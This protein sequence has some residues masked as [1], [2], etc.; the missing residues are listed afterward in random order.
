M[1]RASLFAVKVAVFAAAAVTLVW[2][3]SAPAGPPACPL[4]YAPVICD[5]GRVYPNQCVADRH[6]GRNCVPYGL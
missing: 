1:K 2:V 6:H 3:S 4:I 5:N